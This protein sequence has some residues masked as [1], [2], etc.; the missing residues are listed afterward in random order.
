LAK[1]GLVANMSDYVAGSAWVPSH[2]AELMNL[3]QMIFLTSAAVLF[4][5]TFFAYSTV[6]AAA[7][8]KV[9]GAGEKK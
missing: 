2:A 7:I 3:W 5:F 6:L 9:S 1:A 4:V 8:I